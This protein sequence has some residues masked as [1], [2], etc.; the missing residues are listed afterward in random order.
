MGDYL[1]AS[2]HWLIAAA[3]KSVVRAQKTPSPGVRAQKAPTIWF[4]IN[5]LSDN[6]LFDRVLPKKD[7][8]HLMPACNAMQ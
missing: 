5:A 1:G 4:D 7:I 3:M 6:I 8:G 2:L